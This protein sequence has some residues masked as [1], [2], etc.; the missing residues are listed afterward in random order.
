MNAI[1][2]GGIFFPALLCTLLWGSAFPAVKTGYELF[3]IGDNAYSK[4]FFAGWRFMLAGAAVLAFSAVCGRG[5]TFPR[6]SLW[7]G[8]LLLGFVQTTLQYVFFY[9]GLS[10]TTGVKGSVITAMST[11]LAV[12]A[13]HF[14]F[15]DDRLTRAKTMGCAVGF[16]GVLLITLSSVDAL[17]GGFSLTGEGFMLL[18]TAASGAGAVI[19]KF[20]A[21]GESPMMITGWQLLFGGAVLLLMGTLGGGHFDRVTPG[22]IALLG[23][24]IFL[25]AAAFSIW[26]WLLKKFPVGKVTVYNF[27][28][29]VFGT[30]MSGV[31][32]NETVF[33]ARNMLSLLLVCTGIVLVNRS[34][35]PKNTA[36]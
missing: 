24:L 1:K 34:K 35:E 21:K 27:L 4:L 11:F 26:T 9:I 3:Q 23:Y 2:K 32:L 28:V 36:R 8:I 15:P 25:S 16:A 18:S 6:R 31:I 20:V 14:L 13:S 7:K 30:L 22:A 19:S 12:G 10:H 17:G 5:L 33:T 29:P